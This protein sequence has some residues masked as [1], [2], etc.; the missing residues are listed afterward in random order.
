MCLGE[1]MIALSGLCS[2]ACFLSQCIQVLHACLTMYG[3]NMHAYIMEAAK[4]LCRHVCTF[5]TCSCSIKAEQFVS[6]DIGELVSP[7]VIMSHQPTFSQRNKRC[8]PIELYEQ[9][10]P[11]IAVPNRS[12]HSQSRHVEPSFQSQS[13]TTVAT[14]A[15]VTA[16]AVNKRSRFAILIALTTAFL[17]CLLVVSLVAVILYSPQVRTSSESAADL[18]SRI[19]QLERR[20]EQLQAIQGTNST[21]ATLTSL[22]ESQESMETSIS[23]LSTSVNSQ[24]NSIQS[25]SLQNLRED[26]DRLR[27]VN[28]YQGCTDDTRSCTVSTY[29]NSFY[30]ERACNTATLTVNPHV[31]R[32]KV[33]DLLIVSKYTSAW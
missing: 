20:L 23:R 26:L 15:S 5:S 29:G 6:K 19:E 3:A 18:L 32:L 4:V 33:V 28:L 16:Q 14:G 12:A 1:E 2:C 9:V 10:Q 30:Y 11:E 31:S 13:V 7:L 21:L 25:L 22:Q 17:L 8:E 24:L 27:S